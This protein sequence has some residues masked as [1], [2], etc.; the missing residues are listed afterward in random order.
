[1]NQIP[2]NRRV[3]TNKQRA[4]G[5]AGRSELAAKL[6]TNSSVSR[7]VCERLTIFILFHFLPRLLLFDFQAYRETYSECTQKYQFLSITK[8]SLGAS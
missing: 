3:K 4:K 5:G 2:G 8:I 1:V 6:G 7:S